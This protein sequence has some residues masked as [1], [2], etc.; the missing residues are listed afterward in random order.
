[1]R[2]ERGRE[3]ATSELRERTVYIVGKD[4]APVCATL[5]ALRIE[6]DFVVFYSGVTRVQL[7]LKRRK[8]G[9]LTDDT[10]ALVHV[11]EWLTPGPE[12]SIQ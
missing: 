4:G 8:D 2:D 5:W 3:L 1:M 12:E 6:P 7:L 10:G 9:T 11:W